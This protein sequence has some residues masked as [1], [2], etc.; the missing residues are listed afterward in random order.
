MKTLM[1][2]LPKQLTP[3][4]EERW[5]TARGP[6]KPY[7]VFVSKK[8]LVQLYD[9]GNDIIRISVNRVKMRPNGRWQD[10][11]TWDELFLIKNVIGFAGYCAVEVYPEQAHFINDANMRHLF[12]LPRRPDYA[13]W[14]SA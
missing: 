7:K 14:R 9:E 4:P 3:V 1:D 5:P 8:F 2:P 12:V 6:N 13:W 11:I 10:G